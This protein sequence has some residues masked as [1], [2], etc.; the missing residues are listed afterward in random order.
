[1]KKKSL[2]SSRETVKK[3]RIASS[4]KADVKAGAKVSA[5]MKT[6]GAAMK[7]VGA[8]MKTV[9]APMKTIGAPMKTIGAPLKAL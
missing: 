9:G 2:I 3:A 6:V 4:A 5:P 7:T 1:M 8:P